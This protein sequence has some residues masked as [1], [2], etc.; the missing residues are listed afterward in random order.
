MLASII[1][2]SNGVPYKDIFIFLDDYE[3]KELKRHP[4]NGEIFEYEDL[5]NIYSLE[6]KVNETAYGNIEIKRLPEANPPT[7]EI[8]LY[9]KDYSLL[10]EIGQVIAMQDA[11]FRINILNESTASQDEEFESWL[12]S[13]KFQW[14][15][16]DRLTGRVI[17]REEALLPS[18]SHD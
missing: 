1:K 4:L 17:E 18:K 8:T 12:T 5:Q 7:Y 11:Y 14:G 2:Y 16:R 6:M 15:N 3:I 13:I 10:K 9:Q